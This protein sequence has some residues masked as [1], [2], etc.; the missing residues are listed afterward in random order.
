MKNQFMPMFW[1][2]LLANTM[3]LS[4]LEVGAYVLLIAHAWEHQA[5]VAVMDL[6]RVAKVSNFQW[7]QIRP[8]LSQFFDTS[9]VP[10]F[11]HHERV[12]TE[13][14]RVAEISNKRK[15][16]ALQKHSKSSAK[17]YANDPHLSSYLP[18]ENLNLGKEGETPS[19]QAQGNYRDPGVD[20]RSPPRTKSD[21][22][23]EPVPER[24]ATRRAP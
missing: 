8:R 12:H 18:I 4:T 1:G 16:A 2:D 19:V 5:N 15:E 10:N 14:C 7:H 23:L 9:T 3:H 20:Y 13:L 24:P 17:V 11:W 21:N 22:V 6:Q